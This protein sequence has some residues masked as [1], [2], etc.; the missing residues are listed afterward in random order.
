[1]KVNILQLACFVNKRNCNRFSV[2]D[3]IYNHFLTVGRDGAVKQL[4]GQYVAAQSCYRSAGLLAKTLLMEPKLG[5]EDRTLLQI[6][7]QGV[8]EGF[9]ELDLVMLQEKRN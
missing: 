7:V 1:M 4:L 9:N 2:E 3:L 6:Y 8:S 5:D